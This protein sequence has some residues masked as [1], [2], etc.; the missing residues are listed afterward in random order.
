MRPRPHLL[1]PAPHSVCPSGLAT[2]IPSDSPKPSATA[3]LPGRPILGCLAPMPLAWLR[4]APTPLIPN[5]DV[6]VPTTALQQTAS[7]GFS[8]GSLEL[9]V[10]AQRTPA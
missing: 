2:S 9:H 4:E 7:A 3:L 10:Q 6:W 5:L 8:R 1:P